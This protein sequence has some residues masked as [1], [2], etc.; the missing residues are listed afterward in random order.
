MVLMVTVVLM[1]IFT[2]GC[3]FMMLFVILKMLDFMLK[4]LIRGETSEPDDHRSGQ[5]SVVL[6]WP[7]KHFFVRF[8]D[9]LS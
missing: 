6:I 2:E 7:V 1:V 4:I 9:S 5:C 8:R 3:K